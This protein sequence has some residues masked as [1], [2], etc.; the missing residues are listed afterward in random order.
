MLFSSMVFLW[1]FIPSVII[2]NMIIRT[3]PFRNP[4]T[5]LY[6]R[7]VFLLAASLIFYGWGG[8]YYLLIIISSILINYYGGQLITYKYNTGI[9]KKHCLII[10]IALNLAILFV[11][12]YFNMIVIII[13][14]LLSP[15]EGGILSMKGTGQLGIKEIVL[16]IGISFFT[17][18]AMSYVID[19]YRNDAPV[20]DNILFFAL[21]VSFFPQLIAGPIVRYADIA[22]QITERQETIT[23]KSAGIKRFCYGLGKKV[24]LANAF[25]ETADRIFALEPSAQ[26]GLVAWTGIICYTLQIYYDF[27][28]YSDMAI[29]LGRMFGFRFKE[30]FNYPYISSSIRE[31]WRRWHISLS[32]WFREYVYIPLGGNRRG[33]RRTYLNL[34]IVFLLTGIWHGA[35]FTF[36]FWGIYYGIFLVLERIFLGKLLDNNRFRWLNHLYTILVVMIGWVFFRADNIYL[37]MSYIKG[38]FTFGRSGWTILSYLSMKLILCTAA[39]II[40]CGPIQLKMKSWY[41]ECRKVSWVQKADT[42]IQFSLLILSVMSLI[43]GTYNPFIYFQF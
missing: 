18:Q 16:P 36:I 39:G 34:F 25:A 5:S 4:D 1:I 20:Q 24:L 7:N 8:I 37:A 33:V 29:G 15:G 17:F 23:A 35:N 3:I 42:A 11:F 28:G 9:R 38:L 2:I 12:K 13:E 6:A 10:V 14:N 31:F 27:S 43:A 40:F 41:E 32:T 21:Y 26:T 30:N 22:G 19:V